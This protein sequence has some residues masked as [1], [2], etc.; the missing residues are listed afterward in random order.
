MLERFSKYISESIGEL[1]K[2]TYPK[3][4]EVTGSTIVIIIFIIILGVT[5]GLV[6]AISRVLV[7]FIIDPAHQF[8]LP[9]IF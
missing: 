2:I 1:K 9:N 4:E 6:D 8:H 5:L 3:K 7:L